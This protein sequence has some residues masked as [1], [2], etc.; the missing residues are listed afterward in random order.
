MSY[1]DLTRFHGQFEL[2]VLSR[3]RLMNVLGAGMDADFSN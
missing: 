1:M 2:L 3:C